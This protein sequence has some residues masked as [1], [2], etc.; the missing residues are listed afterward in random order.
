MK[1]VVIAIMLLGV[2]LHLNNHVYAQKGKTK[3]Q[4][5][6]S[7]YKN[8]NKKGFKVNFP[9]V[10]MPDIP[11]INLPEVKAPKISKIKFPEINFP[12]LRMPKFSKPGL[13]LFKSDNKN[14]ASLK[15]P[16]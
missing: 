6:K 7:F 5:A 4:S 11:E 15:C 2:F 13:D 8:D 1:Q 3:C 16:K 10:K 12:K 14:V 9:K